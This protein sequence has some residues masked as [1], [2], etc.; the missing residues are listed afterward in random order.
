M[1][2]ILGA[3]PLLR[4][5]LTGIGNYTFQLARNLNALDAIRDLK[6]AS[7]TGL[8]DVQ[9]ALGAATSDQFPAEKSGS[10]AEP[11]RFGALSSALT[12]WL[13]KQELAVSAYLKLQG[14]W[15]RGFLASFEDTHIYHS[16]NFLLPEFSGRRIV[17]IHDLSTARFPDF[18]PPARVKLVQAMLERVV[19]SDAHI[20]CDSQFIANE[21]ERDFSVK[22]SRVSVVPLGV[23][24]GFD[25]KC[26]SVVAQLE[27]YQLI[28]GQYF[29]VVGTIEPR[30][31]ILRVCEA[32]KRFRESTASKLPIVFVG[33]EGWKSSA[34]HSAIQELQSRGWAK[35]LNYVSDEQLVALYKGAASLVF[36]SIYE[37]FGLPAA[38]A[39]AC[40]CRV[41]TSANSPMAEVVTKR[42]VLVNPLATDEIAAAMRNILDA[43]N[44]TSDDMAAS[45][46]CP[47]TWQDVATD[48]VRV[49][50]SARAPTL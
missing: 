25:K 30:K 32:Y 28:A 3:D 8:V 37:G 43:A 14:K 26:A 48:T 16:P 41:I 19:M 44:E 7:H 13:A 47:R 9:R 2:V 22:P 17:T 4:R 20:I 33:S 10:L 39:I 15:Q 27:R 21:L 11:S 6:F 36:P 1:R 12:A 45:E 46:G 31:N 42:D 40:G 18:H 29:L 35:Y 23:D 24:A 49:Y 5:P 34:E 38:E 50:E